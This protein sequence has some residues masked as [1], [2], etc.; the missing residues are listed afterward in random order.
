MHRDIKKVII[1]H[2]IIRYLTIDESVLGGFPDIHTTIA[3]A[4]KNDIRIGNIRIDFNQPGIEF[5]MADIPG[6]DKAVE[7]RFGRKV[8]AFRAKITNVIICVGL[9]HCRVFLKIPVGKGRIA[10]G[11][12]PAVY[13]YLIAQP[14]IDQ[15][16]IVLTFKVWLAIQPKHFFEELEARPFF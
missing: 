4:G 14:E 2:S 13:L 11:R 10:R 6:Q 9:Q 8:A 5:C 12:E 7:E 16:G 1:Q 15:R 3:K